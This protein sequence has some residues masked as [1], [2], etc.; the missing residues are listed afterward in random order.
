[1]K[2]TNGYILAQ[3]NVRSTSLNLINISGQDTAAPSMSK[4]DQALFINGPIKIF[5]MCR[6]L[7][8]TSELLNTPLAFKTEIVFRGIRDFLP[9]T[10][11]GYFQ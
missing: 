8:R 3:P 5:N 9:R 1:M 10:L 4:Y 2:F 7:S 6:R 11:I